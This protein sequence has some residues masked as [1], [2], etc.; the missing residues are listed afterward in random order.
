MGALREDGIGRLDLAV[1]E[2]ALRLHSKAA[3]AASSS[4]R[5]WGGNFLHFQRKN[6]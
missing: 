3:M 2:H 1:G 6:C 5:F 4:Y